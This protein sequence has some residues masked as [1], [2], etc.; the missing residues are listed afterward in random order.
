MAAGPSPTLVEDCS[1]ESD[2]EQSRDRLPIVLS[3]EEFQVTT[4]PEDVPESPIEL[5]ALGY[6]SLSVRRRTEQSMKVRQVFV[7]GQTNLSYNCLDA[8]LTRGLGDKIA[9]LWEGEPGDVKMFYSLNG[10]EVLE[11]QNY[12]GGNCFGFKFFW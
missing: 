5:Q 6:E 7:G 4:R 2:R 1:P 12:M 8:Q 10:G 11:A 9:I 3:H